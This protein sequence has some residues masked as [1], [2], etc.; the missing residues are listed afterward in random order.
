VAHP[1]NSS[2]STTMRSSRVSHLP[3][4]PMPSKPGSSLTQICDHQSDATYRTQRLRILLT[5]MRPR[6]RRRVSSLRRLHP[7]RSMAPSATAL[8]GFRGSITGIVS[9][10]PSNRRCQ[11]SRRLVSPP[12]RSNIQ[13][14]PNNPAPSCKTTLSPSPAMPYRHLLISHRGR[15]EIE[16]SY[17]SRRHTSIIYVL[18]WHISSSDRILIYVCQMFWTVIACSYSFPHDRPFIPNHQYLFELIFFVSPLPFTYTDAILHPIF[19]ALM[20]LFSSTHF[21]ALSIKVLPVVL[22][23]TSSS[24][25]RFHRSCIS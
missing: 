18:T 3:F 15:R 17:P 11:V 14:Y 16:D 25:P 2:N 19:L 13:I 4:L 22:Q 7:L 12:L 23:S 5:V 10:R 20:L 9:L 21:I 8:P 24:G 1:C 6:L